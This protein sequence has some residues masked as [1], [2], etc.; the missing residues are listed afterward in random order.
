MRRTD[1]RRSSMTQLG[2]KVSEVFENTNGVCIRD[3]EVSR[4]FR[5]KFGGDDFLELYFFNKTND[6]DYTLILHEESASAQ[7]P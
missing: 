4:Q 5:K 7:I 3:P 2:K 1:W 6:F